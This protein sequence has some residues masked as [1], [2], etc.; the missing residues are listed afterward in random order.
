LVLGCV[1]ALVFV[2]NA[3]AADL[4]GIVTYTTDKVTTPAPLT[5]ALVSLYRTDNHQKTVTRT[6]ST[7]EYQFKN[8]QSGEYLVLIE[9]DGRTLYQGKVEVQDSDTQFDIKL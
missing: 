6:S 9:K 5:S 3:A 7:G 2:A 1:L 4:K 8:L